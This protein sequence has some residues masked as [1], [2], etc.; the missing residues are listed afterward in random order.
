M[1]TK[2]CSR[3]KSFDKSNLNVVREKVAAALAAVEEELGVKF[4]LGGC[5][6]REN[7]AKFA[8]SV[9]TVSESGEV[10][11]KE[12]GDFL[13]YAPY[14]GFKPED[15]GATF[16]SN[17]EKFKIIGW[18]HRSHR[19]PILCERVDGARRKFQVSSVLNNLG[20]KQPSAS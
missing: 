15:F 1:S 4:L 3:F 9:A 7:N 19:Y 13:R 17:G 14:H 10:E 11:T 2:W 20:R 8:L 5:T 16:T 6:Y 12:K 18:L